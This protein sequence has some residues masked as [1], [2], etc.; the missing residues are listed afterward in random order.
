MNECSL[1]LDCEYLVDKDYALIISGSS[2][3]CIVLG[4]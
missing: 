2:V 1:L 4:T 3:P